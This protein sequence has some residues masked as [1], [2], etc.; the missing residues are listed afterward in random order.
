[1]IDLAKRRDFVV[2]P[3]AAFK[4]HADTASVEYDVFDDHLG[5]LERIA[6]SS[7]SGI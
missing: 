4:N 2:D 5:L 6:E 7:Q 3:L 1:M